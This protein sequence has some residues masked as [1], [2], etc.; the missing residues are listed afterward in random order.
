VE[1]LWVVQF[2]FI[3]SNLMTN[4]PMEIQSQA[5]SKGF[6]GLTVSATMVSSFK[7]QQERHTASIYQCPATCTCMDLIAT[8]TGKC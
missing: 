8:P 2:P 3:N 1:E 6:S 4:R 5:L 7:L